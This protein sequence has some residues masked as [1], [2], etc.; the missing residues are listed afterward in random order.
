M[1]KLLCPLC[2]EF[3]QEYRIKPMTY[4]YK[5]TEFS[6]NQPGLWCD[7]CGEGIID[8]KNSRAVLPLIQ[9]EKARIDGLLTPEKIK[10][11]RKKL[12]LTQKIAGDLLGGGDNAFSRYEQGKNPIPRPL[13]LL[14]TILDN[15]P[16]QLKEIYP[17]DLSGSKLKKS[18]RE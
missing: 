5:K 18:L 4:K 16:S 3:S 6:I 9:T 14:L 1:T 10:K 8:S 2:G 12:H 7:S 11:I 13:S 15:H 17:G